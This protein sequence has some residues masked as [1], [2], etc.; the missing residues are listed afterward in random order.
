[1]RPYPSAVGLHWVTS[2]GTFAVPYDFVVRAVP[3]QRNR[4]H[5]CGCRRL[6]LV[7]LTFLCC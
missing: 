3:N 2:R 6:R 7:V 5:P 1:M 4:S